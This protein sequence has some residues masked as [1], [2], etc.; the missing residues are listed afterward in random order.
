MKTFNHKMQRSL[1]LI[2]IA[3][4]HKVFGLLQFISLTIV[5]AREEARSIKKKKREKYTLTLKVIPVYS[6]GRKNRFLLNR[7][8]FL[9][10]R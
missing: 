4:A 9:L 10:S 7:K 3:I 8:L 5:T 6:G 1:L 2:N